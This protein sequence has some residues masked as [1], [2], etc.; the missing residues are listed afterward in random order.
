MLR[1][2]LPAALVASPLAAE[3]PRAVTDIAP[4][5]GLVA[6]VMGELGSPEALVPSSASPHDHALSPSEARALQQAEVLFWIGPDLSPGLGRKIEAIAGDTRVVALGELPQTRHLAARDDVLFSGADEDTEDHGHAHAEDD[7][8]DEEG[9]HHGSDDP[10]VWLSPDNARAWLETIA[11]TLAEADPENADTYRANARTAQAAI[12]DAVARATE[13][14]APAREAR[15]VVFHDAYQYF[16]RAFDLDVVGAL[17]LSDAS[18]P[19]PASLSAV[20]DA[21]RDSGARC[22]FAEPQFDPRLIDAVTEGSEIAV[23][24]LDPLGSDIAPG[25]GFY[26]SLVDDLATRIADCASQ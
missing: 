6:S 19:S 7:H 24:E 15:F 13:S 22:V 21:I 11:E 26:P 18:A 1:Y 4:V 23:A 20:R 14:L 2:L 10:H 8:A 5:Q 16:E 12:D 17:S 25:A 9:H 3:P